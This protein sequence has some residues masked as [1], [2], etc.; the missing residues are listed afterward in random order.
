[1]GRCSASAMPEAGPVL[2]LAEL[3]AFDHRATAHGPERRFLCPLPACGEKQRGAQHRSL[4]ANAVNGAWHC[5]RCGARGKLREF[6]TEQT[7]GWT[8]QPRWQLAL[9]RA[10]SLGQPAA[11]EIIVSP[12]PGGTAAKP[13]PRR[14][15]R[16]NRRL[17]ELRAVAGTPAA[18]YLA[19]RGI[20]QVVADQAGVV[21]H[22]AWQHWTK[23]VNR[24][25][26]AGTDQRVVFKL[27]DQ[28]GELV[29]VSAR[30]ID[31]NFIEP[32]VDTRGEK[33]RGLFVTP[34]ALDSDV[35]LITEAPIDALS[36]ASVGYPATAL[37]GTT[38]PDW[39]RRAAAFKTILIGTDNDAAG[40]RAAAQLA[41][42][43][44]LGSRC[45]RLRPT[46]GK[47]WNEA[48]QQL[49][50][51]A[52]AAAV[53]K[54]LAQLHPVDLAP[55][56]TSNHIPAAKPPLPCDSCGA[57]LPPDRWP[58]CAPCFDREFPE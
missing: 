13:S 4:A 18:E 47:D 7:P 16:W 36:L 50:E 8:G 28:A 51:Q 6:W 14:D 41:D 24:W 27:V 42:D 34:G 32:K 15:Q 35:L 3:E 31:G 2:T 54:V 45:Y 57:P 19:G 11:S 49:G 21:Y 58:I 23:E 55:V 25:Q 29:A 46:T 17:Q 56:A 48:L 26:L 44:N 22:G 1:M 12:L 53:A 43:C 52:V 10:F 5:W 30:A 39:L 9:R 38:G 33:R 20:D 37:C 40:D